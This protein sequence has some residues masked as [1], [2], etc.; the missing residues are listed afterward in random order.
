LTGQ[1]TDVIFVDIGLLEAHVSQLFIQL[2]PFSNDEGVPE[3]ELTLMVVDGV[4]TLEG[5][6]GLISPE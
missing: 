6:T 1:D 4:N 5:E 2:V 3:L